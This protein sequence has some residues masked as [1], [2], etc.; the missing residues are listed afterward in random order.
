MNNS[1]IND[2]RS[3]SQLIDARI[4]ELS[5]WRAETLSHIRAFIKQVDSKVIEEW[6]W[7]VP[8]WSHNGIICTGETYKNAIKLTFPNGA[9]LQDPSKL[10]NSSLN[11]KVRRA[12]DFHK[13]DKI[14]E[15]AFKTLILD[16]IEFNIKK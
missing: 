4:I 5:D 15:N 8:I 2:G 14:N 13:D 9:L 1:T 6:K 3:A 10:F 11:G 16:T 7:G 12:I